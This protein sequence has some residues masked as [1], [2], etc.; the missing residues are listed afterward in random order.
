M[1]GVAC[2]A[3]KMENSNISNEVWEGI[4]SYQ[5]IKSLSC[6]DE[7]RNSSILVTGATGFLGY[8]IV[9]SLLMLN[10]SLQLNNEIIVHG[11][12]IDKVMRILGD[13]WKKPNLKVIIGDL[14][15]EIIFPSKSID[16]IIHAAMPAD[17][18]VLAQEPVRVFDSA[19]EGTKNII[20]IASRCHTKSL[21]YISSVTIYG[22]I[23]QKS[24]VDELY[25]DMQDWRND[26]DAY[27]MG[28]RSAEFLLL[29]QARH[30]SLPVKILRPGYIYGANP[31]HDNRVYNSIIENAASGHEIILKS[32][33]LLSRPLVYVMDV[34]KA[35]FLMLASE[36][37]GE[38]YNVSGDNCNLRTYANIAAQK[39][40]VALKY[41]N[42]QDEN[43]CCHGDTQN[44][45]STKKIKKCGWSVNQSMDKQIAEAIMLKKMMTLGW[46]AERWTNDIC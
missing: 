22:E 40:Q 1:G 16:Y 18:N 2:L 13:F 25:M 23:S 44:N 10:D 29:A 39:G 31:F 7:I 42:F 5:E 21:V 26:R 36:C 45:I 33:G 11:R 35:I 3:R 43:Q 38:C 30:N 12:N 14:T 15:E 9:S 20:S 28:K 19:V 34:V 41:E 24:E 37:F 4:E 46:H 6:W 27:M 8:Y 17:S 32:D